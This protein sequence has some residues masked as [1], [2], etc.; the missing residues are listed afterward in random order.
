MQVDHANE[1]TGALMQISSTL[2]SSTYFAAARSPRRCQRRTGQR[3]RPTRRLVPAGT[4][5]ASS[6]VDVG[7]VGRKRIARLMREADI[8]GCHRRERSL[9]I[10]RQDPKA[11]AAPDPT[12]QK[13]S[14]IRYRSS[15]Q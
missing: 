10:I 5:T 4:F 9:S 6:A 14:P 2:G 13:R 8:V 15:D 12:A 11:G 1:D 3:S 7:H